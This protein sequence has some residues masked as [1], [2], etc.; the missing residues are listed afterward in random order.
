MKN[1]T[2]LAVLSLLFKEG[3]VG[4]SHTSIIIICRKLHQYS[5]SQIKESILTLKMGG[6]LV[7]YKTRYGL[8]FRLNHSKLDEIK[9]LIEDRD[10]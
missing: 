1:N 9:K 3:C 7:V 8:D 10:L 2:N 4:R 6:Y 5:C